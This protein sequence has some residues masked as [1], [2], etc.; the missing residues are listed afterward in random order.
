[1]GLV[2]AGGQ[3]TIAV[4]SVSS[5]LPPAVGNLLIQRAVNGNYAV[6]VIRGVTSE[7]ARKV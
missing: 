5:T 7:N 4:R 3:G 1:M 2:L 6:T